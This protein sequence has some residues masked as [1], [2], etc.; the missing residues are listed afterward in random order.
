MMDDQDVL[1]RFRA[2]EVPASRLSVESVVTA[3]RRRTRRRRAVRAGCGV[4][5]AAAA[6]VAVPRL[7]PASDD[8]AEIGVADR[9]TSCTATPLPVP[10]GMTNV[11]ARAIDPN[12][13]YIVGHHI[14]GK[15]DTDPSTRKHTGTAP[16]DAVLWT[17]GRVTALPA[18]LRVVQPTGVNADGVV[19][20]VGSDGKRLDRLLRYVGGIPQQAKLPAGQWELMSYAKINA[21]GD[22]MA[23]AQPVGK[24]AD[25]TVV[26]LWKAGSDSATRV[27]LP[28]G[29][30]GKALTDDGEVVGDLVT[31]STVRPYAWDAAGQGRELPTPHGETGSVN[32]GRGDW[33]IGNLWPSGALVRWKV[34]T[35][36]MTGLDVHAPGHAVNGRG[37]MIADGALRRDDGV[38]KLTQGDPFDVADNGTVVGSVTGESADRTGMVSLGPLSWKCG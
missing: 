11:W 15:P 36:E 30:D 12:G 8:R 13:R 19:V 2:A 25:A 9:V 31:G 29:A 20:A 7:L 37:W 23:T 17:D 5:L 22:I 38:V 26:L 21:R 34:S 1:D 32:N 3:G 24:A 4:A 35:G 28:A 18:P 27:P 10:A 14:T 16:A 33:A 6:V